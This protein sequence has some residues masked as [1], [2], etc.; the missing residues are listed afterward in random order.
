MG[1]DV[2]RQIT[3]IEAQELVLNQLERDQKNRE[4][5]SKV[6]MDQ[7]Q[8]YNAKR[9]ILLTDIEMAERDAEEL[10]AWWETFQVNTMSTDSARIQRI[11]AEIEQYKHEL[12]GLQSAHRDMKD[13]ITRIEAQT[14]DK[15][16]LIEQTTT[17][18][19]SFR[20]QANQATEATAAEASRAEE[21]ALM[22]QQTEALFDEIAEKQLR[23]EALREEAEQ[24]AETLLE[25]E[26]VRD[27][28]QNQAKVVQED[29]EGMKADSVSL[30]RQAEE[31]RLALA[32]AVRVR[33]KLRGDATGATTQAQTEEARHADMRKNLLAFSQSNDAI[34]DALERVHSG[35]EALQEE[36]EELSVDPF[37]DEEQDGAGRSQ[38][39]D[40]E[41]AILA[42]RSAH[43]ELDELTQLCKAATAEAEEAAAALQLLPQVLAEGFAAEARDKTS[44]AVIQKELQRIRA[45]EPVIPVLPGAAAP[46]DLP[47]EEDRLAAQQFSA[48]F[49]DLLS[50]EVTTKD[51]LAALEG[52]IEKH[53]ADI[54]LLQH[55]LNESHFQARSKVTLAEHRRRFAQDKRTRLRVLGQQLAAADE[56]FRVDLRKCEAELSEQERLLQDEF[57]RAAAV[58][59][60]MQRESQ[61][62]SSSGAGAGAKKESSVRELPVQS[63][64]DQQPS[65]KQKAISDVPAGVFDFNFDVESNA[66]AETDPEVE[67]RKKKEKSSG[68]RTKHKLK[69]GRGRDQGAAA[70]GEAA[71]AAKRLPSA[72]TD[73]TVPPLPARGAGPPPRPQDDWGWSD[74]ETS[75][76]L[77]LPPATFARAGGGAAR[78]T[79]TTPQPMGGAENVRM[80]NR[81][82][83]Q[84]ISEAAAAQTKGAPTK[85]PN[86]SR[87]Q[88]DW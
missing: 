67:P 70:E 54:A 66:W 10:E 57:D 9:Q 44:T 71:G 45:H 21:V 73:A 82:K 77:Q 5:N 85:K 32:A 72:K 52:L 14:R 68:G 25:E 64:A 33:D 4:P 12:S 48:H 24:A 20:K 75:N 50:S 80:H 43:D 61:I 19:A 34:C 74:T 29:E 31:G 17:D 3:N 51:K 6:R 30:L 1:T 8:A 47:S 42:A 86:K 63:T 41:Q 39:T 7:L 37:Q 60:D 79:T 55:Q 78:M 28:L 36:L 13:E 59:E 16:F 76:P 69:T 65:K 15:R 35:C 11:A 53:E 87:L 2:A 38:L 26:S 58:L 49:K 40:L 84:S 27:T 62:H 83:V 56:E 88:M 18:L 23:L 46:E 22:L 81:N